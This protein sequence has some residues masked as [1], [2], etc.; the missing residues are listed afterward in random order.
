MFLPFA[1]GCCYGCLLSG[2]L[3]GEWDHFKSF[4]AK[5]ARSRLSGVASLSEA[6]ADTPEMAGRR[7][8]AICCAREADFFHQFENQNKNGTNHPELPRRRLDYDKI[9]RR[10]ARY[11]EPHGAI[12]RRLAERQYAPLGT[13]RA[14]LST[15]TV[16]DAWA[17]FII[18]RDLEA[19][20]RELHRRRNPNISLADLEEAE[21]DCVG[22]SAD[23]RHILP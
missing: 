23:A 10:Q 19:N 20:I 7:D 5:A 22:S 1:E 15:C 6:L 2:R 8:Q 13:F 21:E 12:D 4:R 9:H 3:E 16:P 14:S 17:H 18:K 11:W